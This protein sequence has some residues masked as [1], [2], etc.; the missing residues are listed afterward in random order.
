MVEEH[1]NLLADSAPTIMV[2][3]HTTP[4][5]AAPTTMVEEHINMLAD[6]A[7]TIM[8]EEHT[9]PADAAPTI[10]V[11]E[12]ISTRADAA[13]TLV[14][15]EHINTKVSLG[16][17]YNVALV[18]KHTTSWLSLVNT[19]SIS[20]LA[21][22]ERQ[23]NKDISIISTSSSEGVSAISGAH[24]QI[25]VSIWDVPDLGIMP[26]DDV[27][28]LVQIGIL[29]S[30]GSISTSARAAGPSA[31]APSAAGPSAVDP[32]TGNESALPTGR[33]EQAALPSGRL[34]DNT[35]TWTR[36]VQPRSRRCRQRI[37][38]GAMAR[39]GDLV[40]ITQACPILA[41]R[42]ALGQAHSLNPLYPPRIR[43]Q[44]IL[45][46]EHKGLGGEAYHQW[47]EMANEVGLM[48]AEYDIVPIQERLVNLAITEPHD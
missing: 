6:S 1:I 40:M 9:T 15:E 48:P 34:Q 19:R 36:P 21:A 42:G 28:H 23:A 14:V 10:M 35:Q 18:N 27:L 38:L 47:V 24:D 39:K 26:E 41:L 4:A 33:P 22:G 44:I 20:Q 12:H 46:D 43:V 29:A 31:A 16:A 32:P 3:E 17:E 8:V 13:P 25:G 2:E 37:K 45:G 30:A 7:P 11:E 5:Y